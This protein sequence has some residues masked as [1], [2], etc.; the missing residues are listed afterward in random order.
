MKIK[1]WCTNCKETHSNILSGYSARK[2]TKIQSLEKKGD[3]NL[4]L[5][6]KV[7]I[8]LEQYDNTS[9]EPETEIN[10]KA[11]SWVVDSLIKKVDLKALGAE[12][13]PKTVKINCITRLNK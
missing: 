4:Y 1:F 7:N 5:T 13:I 9:S 2:K 12:T 3:Q 6:N 11:K 8:F 10:L